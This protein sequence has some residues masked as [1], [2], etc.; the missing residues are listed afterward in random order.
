MRAVAYLLYQ[1][2]AAPGSP[3]SRRAEEE[4]VTRFCRLREHTLIATFADPASGPEASRAGLD[5]MF[6]HLDEQAGEFLVLVNDTLHLGDTP[7]AAVDTL[8]R[9]DALGSTV[10]CT[11]E[12]SPDPLLS[13]LNA[14]APSGPGAE[15]RQRIIQGMQARALR[16][17]ALGRS[18][19]GYRIG[20]D[21]R[22]EEAPREAEVVRQI[23]QLYLDGNMGL[24]AL[25]RHLNESGSLTRSGHS[26]SVVS[27]RDIL[28]NRA[29]MG[30]YQRFGLSLPGS[31]AALVSP[32][33]FRRT[34]DLM[35]SRSPR[36]RSVD[37]LPFLLSGL[38]Y[39]AQCG[40]RMIGVTRRQIWRRR[41]GQRMQ[42]TYRY[43]QCHARANQSRCSYHTWRAA[44]LEDTVLEQMRMHVQGDQR[45]DAGR[46]P[47]TAPAA[48]AASSPTTEEGQRRRYMRY[49]KQATDGA[50]SLRR[51]RALLN[52]LK[53]ERSAADTD[54]PS[55][56]ADAIDASRWNAL[57]FA[58]RRKVL[59]QSLDRVDVEDNA[60]EVR[61]RQG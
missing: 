31:H 58:T 8:L 40:S 15:R 57:D 27:L 24:R 47:S 19:F 49:V 44:D 18:P 38:A 61:L 2:G 50:I 1:P 12:G 25:A 28:R 35:R 42:G 17:Q 20:R 53:E 55:N 3:S 16:G 46:G 60:I 5:K 13:L 41:D 10:V 21:G 39:C 48:T 56:T 51:L 36:R 59:Q 54:V 26:W 9:V 45:H 34:Q 22:L 37:A 32:E 7:Q 14:F 23:F 43:Y 11:I 30:T 33:H 29:Y 52:R 4:L 6:R